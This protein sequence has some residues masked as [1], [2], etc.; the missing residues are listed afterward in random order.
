MI[1]LWQDTT[2]GFRI[3]DDGVPVD[4]NPWPLRIVDAPSGAGLPGHKYI[5]FYIGPESILPG[6]VVIALRD[7]ANGKVLWNWQIWVTTTAHSS[8]SNYFAIRDLSY[9][10]NLNNPSTLKT[11]KILHCP[12]GWT[13][14]L[15]LPNRSTST[16]TTKIKIV[17]DSGDAA[18]VIFTVRQGGI[19][20]AAYKGKYY[21]HTVYQWGRKDP[22]IGSAGGYQ[23]KSFFSH[24]Y[25]FTSLSNETVVFNKAMEKSV[26]LW[27]QE[28]Y[29]FDT[30]SGTA[31]SRFDLWNSSITGNQY[32][33]DYK[34]SLFN[35]D[36]TKTV[37]DPCPAGFAV[38]KAN[39]YTGFTTDGL[40]Q[41]TYAGEESHRTHPWDYWCG[42]K[43]SADDAAG[44]PGSFK[45]SYNAS[46]TTSTYT[47][48]IPGSGYRTPERPALFMEEYHGNVW[49][50]LAMTPTIAWDFDWD[51]DQVD[52]IHRNTSY[53]F[54]VYP[55]YEK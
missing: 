15:D 16:R 19:T 27:I 9:R 39:A 21:S 33:N 8:A 10:S 51:P 37:Y 22:F 25:D 45:F 24:Y 14:P 5:Q 1:V 41:S 18:P 49:V 44:V 6:N 20:S 32:T 11:L 35:L 30:S 17:P 43:V 3:I 46:R 48:F 7:R 42:T 26:A 54:G 2:V 12:I 28:P 34:N 13:P 29:N 40:T 36:V 38:P 47:F 23:N 52:P 31:F 53:G 55:A 50:A 4:G